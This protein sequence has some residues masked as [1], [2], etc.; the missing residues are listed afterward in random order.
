MN[1]QSTVSHLLLAPAQSAAGNTT[2]GERAKDAPPKQAALARFL[3]RRRFGRNLD[4]RFGRHFGEHGSLDGR[5]GRHLARSP[6]RLRRHG[7][8][9]GW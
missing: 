1:I 6:Y 4:G 9:L 2:L 5:L 8:V 7:R 3:C